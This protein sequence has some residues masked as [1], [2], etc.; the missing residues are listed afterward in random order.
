VS[1]GS[2]L[3][4]VLIA[5][6]SISGARA[7]TVG[8]HGGACFVGMIETGLIAR[9]GGVP[10]DH[11]PAAASGRLRQ[12]FR[13]GGRLERRPAAA[14]ARAPW[15]ACS[16]NRERASGR[17][18]ARDARSRVGGGRDRRMSTPSSWS[19]G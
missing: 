5:G 8:S 9:C 10:S 7:T 16:A 15:F 17:P 6:T 1:Y 12:M 19:Q 11:G 13:F 4:A 3:A 14:D 2:G 18:P